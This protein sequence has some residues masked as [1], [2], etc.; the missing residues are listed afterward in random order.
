MKPILL[1]NFVPPYRR[2]LYEAMTLLFPDLKVFI[3]TRMESNRNWEV[4]H[5]GLNVVEQK[6]ISV[7]R[8]WKHKAGFE[9]SLP[10]HFPLDTISSL[11][12]EN[13]EVV[14]SV[15]LGFR[16]YMAM[17]YCKAN[18]KP[19]IL[20]VALSEHTEIS[21]GDFRKRLRKKL[22]KEATAVFCNG[23][24]SERYIRSMGFQKKVCFVPCTS[25][26]SINKN[27]P[28]PRKIRRVLFTGQLTSRKGILEMVNGFIELLRQTPSLK[29]HLT[30]AGE[31]VEKNQLDK[32][33]NHPQIQLTLKGAVRYEDMKQLYLESDLYIF[34]TLADEWGVVVNEALSSGLVVI[35]SK[36]SQAVEELIVE[37]ENGWIFDPTNPKSFVDKVKTALT[38]EDEELMKMKKN[39]T[40]SIEDFN[41]KQVAEKIK[42]TLEEVTNA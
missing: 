5:S 29:F 38:I 11:K 25:D 40:R 21:R 35:G 36:F 39:A 18:K 31:G 17:K 19:L 20:W 12:R 6:G 22:L 28:T 14:I 15:E 33:K 9:E 32:L 10:I 24:S 7:L 27:L 3:S 16:S 41:P 26:Y 8:K 30:V 37:G 1:T 23:K 34:P 42:K 13:P 2:S 4:N